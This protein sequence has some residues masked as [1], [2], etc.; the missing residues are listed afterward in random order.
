MK[1]LQIWESNSIYAMLED[2]IR[3]DKYNIHPNNLN[4]FLEMSIFLSGWGIY[5]AK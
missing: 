5:G 2:Q 3:A 4:A 1:V